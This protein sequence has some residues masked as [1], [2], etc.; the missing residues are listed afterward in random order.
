MGQ[1]GTARTGD[2]QQAMVH[3]TIGDTARHRM[4]SHR[5][6]EGSS[7]QYGAAWVGCLPAGHRPPCRWD[8]GHGPARWFR[9]SRRNGSQFD[10]DPSTVSGLVGLS[11]SRAGGHADCVRLLIDRNA[12]VNVAA[13]DDGAFSHGESRDCRRCRRAWQCRHGSQ[14]SAALRDTGDTPLH[15]AI[16]VGNIEIVTALLGAGQCYEG[17]VRL[18]HRAAC[19]CT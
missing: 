8:S 10:F 18:L 13:Y 9:F 14:Q 1:P 3:D 7:A 17:I 16:M 12:S 6:R 4:A 11:L 2:S 5:R 19:G 15:K